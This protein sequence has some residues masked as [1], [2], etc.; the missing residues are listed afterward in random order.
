M[1]KNLLDSSPDSKAGQRGSVLTVSQH[2]S[3]ML[4]EEQSQ[5]A[6][7]EGGVV[8][9]AGVGLIGVTDRGSGYRERSLPSL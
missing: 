1:W 8:A 3:D 4:D 2:R 5:R 9:G 6:S 7:P